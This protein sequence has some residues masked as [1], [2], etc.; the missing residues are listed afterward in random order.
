MCGES[1][2]LNEQ[3]RSNEARRRAYPSLFAVVGQA[4]ATLFVAIFPLI[5]LLAAIF[6]CTASS[7]TD[8]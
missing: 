1:G 7:T 3:A 4:N 2:E 8:E 5:G 6:M